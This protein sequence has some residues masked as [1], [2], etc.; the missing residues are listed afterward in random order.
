[1]AGREALRAIIELAET[2]RGLELMGAEIRRTK[3]ISNALEYLVIPSLELTIRSLSMKFE[4][5]DR[6]EKARLKRV[7]V[8]LARATE[9]HEADR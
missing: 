6:E 9:A 1:M 2:Q 4:E 8:L 7:K 3:R 5:R